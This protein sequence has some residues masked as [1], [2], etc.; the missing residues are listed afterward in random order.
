MPVAG[1]APSKIVCVGRN[2]AAHARELGHD[3]P[4]EPLIF[5]KPPSARIAS[6]EAVRLPAGVGR[7]DFEGEIAFVVGRRVRNL[8]PDEG[9]S[10]LSHVLAANDVTARDLQRTD[11]QWTRAKG[12]D[13]F[14]PLG[15]PVPLGDVDLD[16]LELRTLVNG[17]LRQA[18]RIGDMIFPPP[19]LVAF[20]SG[21]MTLE[22]GDLILTG[23]PEG[24]GPVEPGDTVEVRIPGVPVLENP[25]SAA[26]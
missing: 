19:V 20:I 23:T 1:P 25:V 4:T 17:E 22:P 3:V 5:L 26:S 14:L 21:I 9:W 2:Y 10:A 13:T 12:F 18:G 11:P 7:V 16:A 8:P 6:G 15:E 24:V